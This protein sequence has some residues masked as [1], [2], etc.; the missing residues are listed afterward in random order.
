MLQGP[1]LSFRMPN[2]ILCRI[3]S[4]ETAKRHGDDAGN[5]NSIWCSG[6]DSLLARAARLAES[7]S[8]FPGLTAPVDSDWVRSLYLLAADNDA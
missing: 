5:D 3:I 6:R 2:H 1:A 7:M 8:E 4:R